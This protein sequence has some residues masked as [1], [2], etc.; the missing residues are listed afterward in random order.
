MRTL[1]RLGIGDKL[2]HGTAYAILGFLPSLHE[3]RPTLAAT[4]LGAIL[5]GVLLEFAQRL[6][7]GRT[8]EIADMAANTCGALCGM[9]L[10]LPFRQQTAPLDWN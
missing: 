4:L 1:G 9:L 5:L 10:A 7:P 6:S 3:R 2:L 8:F